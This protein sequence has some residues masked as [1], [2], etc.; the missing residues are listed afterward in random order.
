M[1]ATKLSQ[2]RRGSVL[3]KAQEQRHEGLRTEHTSLSPPIASLRS[4]NGSSQALLL[5]GSYGHSD[6]IKT[7]NETEVL[8]LYLG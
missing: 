4:R 2:G 7:T 3:S 1:T 8:E 5:P 6:S